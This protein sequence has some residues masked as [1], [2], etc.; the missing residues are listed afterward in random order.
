[1]LQQLSNTAYWKVIHDQPFIDQ[2]YL[3]QL[4]NRKERDAGSTLNSYFTLTEIKKHATS[5]FK[6]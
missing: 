5:D 2:K 4:S 1:M 3:I 6:T